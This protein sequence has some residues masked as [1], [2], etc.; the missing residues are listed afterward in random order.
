M[1]LTTRLAVLAALSLPVATA[2]PLET[3]LAQT[4]PAP[5]TATLL[6]RIEEQDKKIEALEHKLEV[7]EQQLPTLGSELWRSSNRR[8]LLHGCS[9]TGDCAAAVD[10]ESISACTRVLSRTRHAA[11]LHT[12]PDSTA[13]VQRRHRVGCLLLDPTS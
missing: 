2:L 10:V 3:A 8:R 1:P 7:L 9:G 4:S 6:K 12:R 11:G 5:D 13:S